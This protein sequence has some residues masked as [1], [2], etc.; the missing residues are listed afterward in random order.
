MVATAANGR[1]E[2]EA[3]LLLAIEGPKPQGAVRRG[4]DELLILGHR[5]GGDLHH[6]AQTEAADL[7]HLALKRWL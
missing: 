5:E 1:V 2:A 4:G 7:G 3:A 6:V